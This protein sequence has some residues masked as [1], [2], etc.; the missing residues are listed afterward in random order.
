MGWS[1]VGFY[2]SAPWL[3]IKV[4]FTPPK[5]HLVAQN[6]PIKAKCFP[7]LILTCHKH[8]LLPWRC[9]PNPKSSSPN[10]PVPSTSS[11]AHPQSPTCCL[12]SLSHWS[13]WS[14]CRFSLRYFPFHRFSWGPIVYMIGNFLSVLSI[15]IWT[16]PTILLFENHTQLGFK[17]AIFIV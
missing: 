4:T 7:Y 12:I 15:G 1:Y 17:L 16:I 8:N 3:C 5:N 10:V 6:P 9:S 14:I 13:S 2:T 11:P